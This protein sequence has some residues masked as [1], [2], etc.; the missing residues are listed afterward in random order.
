MAT[1]I[2]Q[3]QVAVLLLAT[4]FFGERIKTDYNEF[5]A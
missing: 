4:N 3:M 1:I 2:A 5:K